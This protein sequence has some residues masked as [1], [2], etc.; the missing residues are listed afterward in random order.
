[1]TQICE[2]KSSTGYSR[3][4]IVSIKFMDRSSC[5]GVF[6]KKGV[7]RNFAK[8]TGKHPYQRFFFNKVADLYNFIRKE[9]QAQ[10]FSCKFC[11]ISKSTFF[12][13]TP[14]AAAS[15]WRYLHVKFHHF[16]KKE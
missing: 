10:V 14:P 1:M 13:R 8:F 4:T 6:C 9:T 11:E 2:K 3:R 16:I 15:A 12:Y 5:P 7:V